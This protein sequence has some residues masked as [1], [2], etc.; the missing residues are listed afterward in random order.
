MTILNRIEIEPRSV[1]HDQHEILEWIKHLHC[2]DG[3]EVDATWGNG[4]F[5]KCPT[6]WPAKRFDID[7]TR[8]HCETA[9]S[10]S[11]PLG[12]SSVSSIVFDPPFLTYVRSA[13][14]GNGNMV[15]AKR[16]AGYWRYDELEHHYRKSLEEFRRVLAPKGI[17]VFKCQDIVHNHRLH[18]T[19]MNVAIWGAELGFRV[20]DNFILSAK[21]RM[22]R[23]NRKGPAKHA[24]IHHSHFLVLE[25][26][27]RKEARNDD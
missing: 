2:P 11:L 9:C 24:R 21:H 23:P 14:T 13:R 27:K 12:D 7:P 22:P 10:T 1:S 25:L 20:K 8:N 26:L 4:S 6:Q 15:M 5:Y 18:S 3:F 17:V 19:H 16:F